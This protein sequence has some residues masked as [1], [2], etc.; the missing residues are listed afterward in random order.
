MEDEKSHFRRDLNK[1]TLV[2]S[3]MLA[4]FK[5]VFKEGHLITKVIN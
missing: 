2:F 5:T 4:E 3:H 1:L